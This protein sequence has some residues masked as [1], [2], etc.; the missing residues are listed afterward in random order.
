[1]NIRTIATLA[2]AV[3]L[4]IIAVV[5]VR[6]YL[7][8]ARK[9]A[10]APGVA[11]STPVVVASAPIIRGAALQPIQLKVANYPADAVPAG[12]FQT[13]AQLVGTGATARLALRP[14]SLNEP[15]LADQVS[16][17]GGKLTL[18]VTLTPGMRAVSLRSSDVAGVA[19]FVL[20][21]D[22][23]DILLTRTMGG[24]E[25]ANAVTQALAENVLVLGIDQASDDTADKPV[26]ARTVTV[27][28]TP[29]QAESIS[30]AQTVGQVSFSLRHVS[31]NAPL[32]RKAFTVAQLGYFAPVRAPAAPAAAAARAA[33][34]RTPRGMS[35]VTVARGVD[36]STYAV[37]MR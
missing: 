21:G 30:L 32:T 9:G 10:V 28:V 27:E 12:S 23:V 14:M 1:M 6:S 5:A 26:V 13:V 18:S 31:D 25:T 37:T 3:F 22:R 7:G 24:G 15:I 11:G 35:E 8:A 33:A 19:G 4:G 2:V 16:G 17:P 29:V 34:P 36:V 20:P